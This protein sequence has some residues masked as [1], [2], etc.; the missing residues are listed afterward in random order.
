MEMTTAE[1][2]SKVVTSDPVLLVAQREAHE[3]LLAWYSVAPADGQL[4]MKATPLQRMLHTRMTTSEFVFKMKRY[5]EERRRLGLPT[6][7]SKRHASSRR[8]IY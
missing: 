2:P 6:S 3:G 7:S 1:A 5:H 4:P 8:G